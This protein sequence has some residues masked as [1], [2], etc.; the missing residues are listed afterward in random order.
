ME[1]LAL[2]IALTAAG[3]GIGWG[4]STSR[5]AARE[6][7]MQREADRVRHAFEAS[8]ARREA[9]VRRLTSAVIDTLRN[10]RNEAIFRE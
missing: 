6:E 1:I 3:I 5:Q 9:D 2:I 8:L 10:P 7:A 4:L